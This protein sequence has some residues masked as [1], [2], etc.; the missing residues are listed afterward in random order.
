M[1][2]LAI[3]DYHIDTKALSTYIL[4]PAYYRLAKSEVRIAL[5]LHGRGEHGIPLP[6]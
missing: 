5:W 3:T 4:H 2:L 6:N 1:I